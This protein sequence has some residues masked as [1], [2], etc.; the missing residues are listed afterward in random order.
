MRKAAFHNLG[1][2]VNSYETEAMQELLEEA[3][4]EIVPFGEGADVY[5]VNTCSVTNVADKKSRQ[6]LHRARKLNPGAVVAA[7]GCYAQAAGEELKRDGAVD[8]VIGNNRKK[9]LPAILERYFADHR[10]N[11]EIVDIGREQEYERLRI[12]RVSDHTRAFMKVQ[13]GCN[14]FCSYCIIPYTRGRVRSRSPLEVIREA[15]E[16]AAAGY[17]E[18]VLTG[19]HLSSYGADFAK[20]GEC[21]QDG[22]P[23]CR[24]R[25]IRPDEIHGLLALIVRLDQIRGLERIR[26]G[27]LEPRIV[28]E[29]F[30]QTLASLR[31]ICPHFHLSLQSG[32]EATLKRMNRKY[33]P[34]EYF[35]K[36]TLLRSVFDNPAITTDVIV[37]FPGETE[38]EFRETRAFLEKTGFYEM[39]I[40]KYSKRAGTRA[41]AMPDQIPEAVK[42][43]RSDVL[44]SLNETLSEAYRKRFSGRETDLLLEEPVIINGVRYMMGH[45]RQYV[46]GI[47]PYE[48]GMKNRIIRVRLEE[49]INGEFY[50]ANPCKSPQLQN[51]LAEYHILE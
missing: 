34:E 15:E 20:A 39:H 49:L 43:A 37:G 22:S 33:T 7:V 41:A 6:M 9:D 19:I 26:L 32:C 13:D 46:K 4:Y 42:A 21:P 36:C 14:Q 51:L 16:L 27:S 2:K 11:R 30:A 48:E 28:T 45:T 35:E 47:L 18:I 3:G 24:S 29:D 38:E 25:E 50:L 44:L 17:K 1:C 31:T 5:V 10:Q 8:L 12:S 40:F 23:R